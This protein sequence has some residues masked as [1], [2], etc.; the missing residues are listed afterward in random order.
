MQAN[1]N[2]A[3]K[4]RSLWV[5]VWKR[6]RKNTSAVIGMVLFLCILLVCLSAPI[7]YN[8]EKDIIAV[9]I[10]KQLQGPSQAHLLGADE[11]GRDVLAR[12]I[13]GG[14][15]TLLI[16]F[17]A[18][19]VAFTLGC[20][21]GTAAAYYGRFADTLIMRFI[22]IIMSVP[23][24]LLMITFATIMT[25][26]TTSLIFVVGFG[27]VPNQARMIRGQVLQ[28]VDNEYIEA[29]RIQ[30]ASDLKIIT[31]HILPNALSPIITTVIL[32][33]AY[34]VMVIST[35]SFLGLGVQ[36]PDPEWGAMLAGGRIYIR[37]AWHITTFPGMALVIT[38]MSLTLLGDGVRDALD[39][40]MKR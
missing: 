21:L 3:Y 10:S 9:D 35:L 38:L 15:T 20:I 39:P 7:L 13:W 30:G 34:A 17:C 23:P 16:S 5:D 37:Y 28:V 19:I 31:S 33:I 26:S 8:Y 11:L 18:L 32:D 12:I 14:R 6:L 40:R 27:L 29:V 4:K 24:I 25:P 1:K 22:D 2:N 36:A